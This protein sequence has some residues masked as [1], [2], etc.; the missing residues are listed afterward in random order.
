[1]VYVIIIGRPIWATLYFVHMAYF[2]GLMCHSLQV[3][4]DVSSQALI[5]GV[6]IIIEMMTLFCSSSPGKPGSK[7]LTV[8]PDSRIFCLFSSSSFFL[9][10]SNLK[11]VHY[12]WRRFKS[13]TLLEL[14]GIALMIGVLIIIE[15]MT[16]FCSSSPSP[17][18]TT[19]VSNFQAPNHATQL[20]YKVIVPQTVIS[21]D[22]CKIL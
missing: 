19:R 2:H 20:T 13:G 11:C 12:C 15:M 18:A 10:Q 7:R 21:N 22:S 16:L 3:V 8:L 9:Q 1:M 4:D 5:I 6:L 17:T 14:E